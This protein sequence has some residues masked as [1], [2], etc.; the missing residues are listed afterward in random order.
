MPIDENIKI[1]EDD[2]KNVSDRQLIM[3]KFIDK[4]KQNKKIIF[5]HHL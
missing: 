1:L 2:N 5:Y 3:D 4:Y